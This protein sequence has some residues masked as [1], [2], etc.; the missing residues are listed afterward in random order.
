[1]ASME[2]VTSRSA[3]GSFR[4]A[5]AS[6]VRDTRAGR[7]VPRR[8]ANTAAPSVPATIDPRRKPSSA[9]REKSHVAMSPVMAAVAR[10]PMSAR[11]PAGTITGRT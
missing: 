8:S 10:V 6:R 3:T 4:P 7:F 11:D 2:P 9:D 1:M 5:S